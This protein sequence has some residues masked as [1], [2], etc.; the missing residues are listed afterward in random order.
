MAELLS[1]LNQVSSLVV[2]ATLGVNAVAFLWN[3]GLQRNRIGLW[4]KI[5]I[6]LFLLTSFIFMLSSFVLIFYENV[7]ISNM[8]LLGYW[9][10]TSASAM[11][12]IAFI[13]EI[14]IRKEKR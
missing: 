2:L 11:L 9:L 5:T 7:V 1:M 8:I 3:V 10:L 13:E 12:L 6:I 14:Y 4:L